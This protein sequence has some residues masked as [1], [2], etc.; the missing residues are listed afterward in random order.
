MRWIEFAN[1]H[2]GHSMDSPASIGIEYWYG[3]LFVFPSQMLWWDK[4]KDPGAHYFVNYSLQ[5]LNEFRKMHRPE[6]KIHRD[7]PNRI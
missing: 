7:Q 6:N 5:Y 1:K 3:R 2:A 4:N